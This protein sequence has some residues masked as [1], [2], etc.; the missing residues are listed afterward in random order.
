MPRNEAKPLSLTD[1]RRQRVNQRVLEGLTE[2]TVKYTKRDGTESSST[3]KVAYFNGLIGY[4]TGSVTID[5]LDKG[6]RTINLHRIHH[7]E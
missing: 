6:P 1:A 2:V 3:G 5:T 4:D 7:I